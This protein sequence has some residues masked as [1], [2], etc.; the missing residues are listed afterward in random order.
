[1]RVGGEAR[2]LGLNA[3]MK[4]FLQIQWRFQKLLCTSSS[5][6]R[7]AGTIV[8]SGVFIYNLI[9]SCRRAWKPGQPRVLPV[10]DQLG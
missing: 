3:H 4:G 8:W 5:C 1:M 10:F 7:I 2:K 6:L 9:G